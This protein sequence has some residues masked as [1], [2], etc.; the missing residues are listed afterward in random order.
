[1]IYVR[2]VKREAPS[3]LIRVG[4]GV[5]AVAFLVVILV[6]IWAVADLSWSRSQQ[7]LATMITPVLSGALI[8]RSTHTIPAY[9]VNAA[10]TI[11]MVAVG[12][13][14]DTFQWANLIL[15]FSVSYATRERISL[16]ALFAGFAGV[17]FY[18]ASFR[19]EDLTVGAMVMALWFVIWMLGRMQGAKQVEDQLR[20]DRDVAAELAAT[21][22][23]RLDLEA[24]RT[25]MARELHDLIGHTVNV[26][27]VHAGAGRRAVEKDPAGAEQAFATIETTG[28][29]ALE[30]LD[31]VLGLLRNGDPDAPLTP[32]PGMTDLP[33]LLDEFRGAGL[34]VELN[35]S[36]S[37]EELPAGIG[38]TT[39]R[40]VQEA[41]TNTL[42]HSNVKV[43]E[44]TLTVDD[45]AV[46]VVATDRGGGPS[47]LSETGGRGLEGITERVALH[48]GTARFGQVPDGF[49]VS[50]TIPLGGAR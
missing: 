5:I 46:Q 9:F 42:K 23:A 14:S 13:Q 3:R 21:R 33:R 15:L 45:D 50:C 31:R 26:M 16:I 24:Q 18:F 29:S 20:I 7:V 47:M 17:V 4:D 19:D 38:L 40:V 11:A 30:E 36:G 6:E 8:F 35:T 2:S 41:L 25:N 48:G 1:M 12:F 49:E 43:S 10:T 27:V 44:V 32:L 34:D 28:R 39:Y 37:V 22:A